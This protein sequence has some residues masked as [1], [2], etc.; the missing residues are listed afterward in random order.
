MGP[1]HLR[2]YAFILLT[3]LVVAGCSKAK[4]KNTATTPPISASVERVLPQPERM[5]SVAFSPDGQ[6]LATGGVEPAVNIWRVADG[7]LVRKLP[8]PM[9]ATWVAISHDGHDVA[10]GSY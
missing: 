6:Y 7:A 9:G 2:L 1:I 5:W 4:P 10:S 3:T 8:Q